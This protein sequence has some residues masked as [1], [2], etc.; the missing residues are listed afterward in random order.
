M[1]IIQIDTEDSRDVNALLLA[2]Q[3]DSWARTGNGAYVVP[4]SKPGKTY[5]TT[6]AFCSCPDAARGNRCK[7]Q[8]AVAIRQALTGVPD[9]RPRYVAAVEA[10]CAPQDKLAEDRLWARFND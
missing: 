1:A 8:R 10:S 2:A 4:A 5:L 3:S 6:P 7:H 9:P